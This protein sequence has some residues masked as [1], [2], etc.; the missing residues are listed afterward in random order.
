MA[1]HEGDDKLLRDMREKFTAWTQFW[2]ENHKEGDRD[3]D[4]LS[5]E[6]GPWPIEEI[7]RRKALDRPVV[8][9]DIVSQ[10]NR[11][12]VN[13]ARLNPRGIVIT[14][15]GTEANDDTAQ[16]REDRI[17]QIDYDSM[18]VHARINAAQNAVDRGIGFFMVTTDFIRHDSFDQKIGTRQ[19][20]NSKSVILDPYAKEVDWSDMQGAFVIDRYPYGKY[21]SSFPEAEVRSFDDTYASVAPGWLDDKSV[22]VCEYWCVKNKRR[23]LL[24]IRMPEGMV[25]KYLDEL[26]GAKLKDKILTWNGTHIPVE[27]QRDVDEPTVWQYL[28]NGLEILKRTPWAGSTIPIIMVTGYRKYENGKLVIESATRK[29][30]AGQLLYDYATTAEQEVL[31]MAPKSHWN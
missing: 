30:R 31:G 6:Y 17:R 14:P 16:M 4:C 26:E 22:Q 7:R 23:K 20:P 12:I 18:A 2:A 1:K 27:R 5:A 25:K 28:T 24:S 21:R 9:V 13:Q 3:M 19:I 10:F 29:M 8:H 11:R 15:V